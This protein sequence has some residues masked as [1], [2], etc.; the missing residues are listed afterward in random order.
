MIREE[1]GIMEEKDRDILKSLFF[2][3]KNFFM[4]WLFQ[5]SIVKS[6][7]ETGNPTK[8]NRQ[9][10]SHSKGLNILLSEI[11]QETTW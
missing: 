11:N 7:S 2:L 4:L 1:S 8:E 6:N 5:V 10:H 9:I 3:K